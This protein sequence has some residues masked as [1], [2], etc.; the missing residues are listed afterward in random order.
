MS[1][2]KM[3]SSILR[4]PFTGKTIYEAFAIISKLYIFSVQCFRVEGHFQFLNR[5]PYPFYT[6]SCSVPTSTTNLLGFSLLPPDTWMCSLISKVMMSCSRRCSNSSLSNS[7]LASS[8]RFF[9]RAS[10]WSG[11]MPHTPNTLQIKGRE[12]GCQYRRYGPEEWSGKGVGRKN[13]RNRT[14]NNQG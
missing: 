5:T 14:Y 8:T 1:F 4:I 12:K 9:F 10:W 7:C 11:C 6:L 2:L 13:K 3:S